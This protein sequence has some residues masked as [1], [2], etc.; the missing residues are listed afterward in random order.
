MLDTI[1]AYCSYVGPMDR[2]LMYYL[3]HY[4][5]GKDWKQSKANKPKKA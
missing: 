4:M 2:Q 1:L 3:D 5:T